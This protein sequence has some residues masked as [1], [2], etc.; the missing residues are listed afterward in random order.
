MILPLRD[1]WENEA[2]KVGRQT[3]HLDGQLHDIGVNVQC[4]ETNQC[5]SSDSAN[6]Y[7]LN[8]RS[9]RL[10][11]EFVLFIRSHLQS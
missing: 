4:S 6:S 10:D 8:F 11:H 9:R 3:T 5:T 1:N 7:N 2:V